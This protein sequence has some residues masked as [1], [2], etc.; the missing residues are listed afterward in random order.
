VRAEEAK[1][2]AEEA[3]KEKQRESIRQEAST[4]LARLT[5]PCFPEAQENYF[6]KFRE[7][8]P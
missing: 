1:E 5:F 6:Y 4:E 7:F 3:E 8:I 2:R